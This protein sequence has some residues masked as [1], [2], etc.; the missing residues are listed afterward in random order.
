VNVAITT[1]L[2]LADATADDN[3]AGG[4]THR[5]QSDEARSITA[6]DPLMAS[7]PVN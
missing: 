5:R 2:N 3:Q 7:V 4:Y 6:V 1:A